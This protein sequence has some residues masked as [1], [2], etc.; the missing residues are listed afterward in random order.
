MRNVM[1][2]AFLDELEKIAAAEKKPKK[3]KKKKPESNVMKFLKGTALN[4]GMLG[5]NAALGHAMQS[6]MDVPNEKL[7]DAVKAKTPKGVNLIEGG[8]SPLGADGPHFSAGRSGP[9]AAHLGHLTD[10]DPYIQTGGSKNPAILGHELG[11]VDINNSRVGRLVQN[12]LTTN[13]GARSAGIGPLTGG[14]TGAF[15]D[16][17]TVRKAGLLAPL[18]TSA[19]Q[20]AYEAAASIQGLRR[21]RGAGAHGKELLQGIKTLAPAFG[22]YATQAGLGVGNA[23]QGQAIG[24]GIRNLV[25]ED[26]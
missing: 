3:E 6:Q 14:L 2:T 22:T 13:L 16:N 20:L 5:G 11:H 15:S 9:L 12:P 26:E 24:G 1:K 21:M 8:D 19:P 17:E 10:H 18:L 4:V 23:M 25:R 7:Y